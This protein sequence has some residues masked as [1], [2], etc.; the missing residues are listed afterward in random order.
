[1][2]R[3]QIALMYSEKALAPLVLDCAFQIS[4]ERPTA[5]RASN[6]LHD[7]YK[8]GDRNVAKFVLG[9]AYAWEQP[10]KNFQRVRTRRQL[11]RV[12]AIGAATIP[13]LALPTRS[14]SAQNQ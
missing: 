13:L 1:M 8:K 14:E 3:V 5:G 6:L 10:V 2:R 12:T 11:L 4:R 7:Y 9:I